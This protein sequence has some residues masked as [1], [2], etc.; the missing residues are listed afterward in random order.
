M[1]AI[2]LGYEPAR[3]L[4]AAAYD[5]WLSD[6]GLPQKFGTQYR[7][8]GGRWILLPVDSSTTDEERGE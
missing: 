8:E 5:R 1:R 2:E 3:W 7:S 6:A 4:A